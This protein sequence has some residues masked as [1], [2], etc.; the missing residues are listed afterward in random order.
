MPTSKSCKFTL[1]I[2]QHQQTIYSDVMKL[3][4]VPKLH[5]CMYTGQKN[6]ITSQ[7]VKLVVLPICSCSESTLQLSIINNLR[8]QSWQV[9]LSSSWL[10]HVY[11][12]HSWHSL[13]WWG[14][15]IVEFSKWWFMQRSK[16]RLCRNGT[17]QALVRLM[18]NRIS[19]L[20]LC[21]LCSKHIYGYLA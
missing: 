15:G 16:M 18:E 11:C 19:N 7:H 6:T 12:V 1:W 13:T 8:S 2:T 20:I 14:R 21:L 3:H 5:I 4:L 10:K 9:L 17:V